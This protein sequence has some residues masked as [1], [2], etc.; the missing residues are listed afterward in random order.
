MQCSSVASPEP[1]EPDDDHF[2][3]FDGQFH[4]PTSTLLAPNRLWI[5][6]IGAG[7]FMRR[8]PFPFGVPVGR[9]LVFPMRA[10]PRNSSYGRALT[11]LVS[12]LVLIGVV[13]AAVFG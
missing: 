6:C 4:A 11:V 9:Q 5:S 2:A 3:A 8:T 10:L 12:L 7:R 13:A 1:A